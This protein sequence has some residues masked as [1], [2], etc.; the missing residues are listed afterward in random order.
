MTEATERILAA[1]RAVPA[2]RVAAYG[3]VARAAGLPNGARQVA[4]VLHALS[5]SQ[6]LPWHRILRADGAIALPPGAGRELQ[7]ALLAAE[8]VD[9]R[10]GCRVEMRV[11]QSK[12]LR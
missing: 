8:G 4:R 5:R 2:G 1:I 10:D 3:D 9:V 11:Y 7:A 12:S 6:N